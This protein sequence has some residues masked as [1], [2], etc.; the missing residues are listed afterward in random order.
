MLSSFAWAS[1]E[2]PPIVV[3]CRVA[4]FRGQNL[5]MGY[6]HKKDI[7]TKPYKSKI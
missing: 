2:A 3:K 1:L 6:I 4:N 7:S 5:I